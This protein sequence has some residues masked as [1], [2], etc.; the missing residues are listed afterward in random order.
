MQS[1]MGPKIICVEYQL[2][3]SICMDRGLIFLAHIFNLSS[4]PNQPSLGEVK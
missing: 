1:L 3:I 4:E 2:S